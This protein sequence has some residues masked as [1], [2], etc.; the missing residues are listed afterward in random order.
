MSTHDDALTES[1]I[2]DW[3]GRLIYKLRECEDLAEE[4]RGTVDDHTIDYI[5]NG[6]LLTS[7]TV[8]GEARGLRQKLQT[9]SEG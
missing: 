5:L 8:S 4:M 2:N 1:E 9:I 6:L 3:E 7:L